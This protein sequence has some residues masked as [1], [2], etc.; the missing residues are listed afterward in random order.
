MERITLIQQI[1][2]PTYFKQYPQI[3]IATKTVTPGQIEQTLHTELKKHRPIHTYT[4]ITQLKNWLEANRLH[5][6][7]ER[8]SL[9]VAGKDMNQRSYTWI[10]KYER[11]HSFQDFNRPDHQPEIQKRRSR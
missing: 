2:T 6:D 5:Q 8:R 3:L 1:D 10:I 4:T 11:Y 9:K 7:Q